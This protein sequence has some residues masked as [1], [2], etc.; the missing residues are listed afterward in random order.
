MN[1]NW[2][3][4]ASPIIL[5]GK[6]VLLK[7]ISPLANAWIIPEGVIQEVEAKRP[8]ESYLS[9]VSSVILQSPSSSIL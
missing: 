7:T 6:A 9:D 5:L 8:I 4:N 1:R 3:L 2:V